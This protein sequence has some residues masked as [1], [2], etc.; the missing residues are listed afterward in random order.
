M[1]LNEV[2]FSDL[3]GERAPV[4]RLTRGKEQLLKDNLIG[5]GASKV[6]YNTCKVYNRA[7]P[8]RTIKPTQKKKKKND[9]MPTPSGL[10]LNARGIRCG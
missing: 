3:V 8:S 10:R 7:M 1:L 9:I 2:S 5:I 6:V 4:V